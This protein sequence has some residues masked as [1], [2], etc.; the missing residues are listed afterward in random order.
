MQ[1]RR[2]VPEAIAVPL[3]DDQCLSAV[4]PDDDLYTTIL[5]V[6]EHLVGVRPLFEPDAMSI[7]NDG[8][9][10]PSSIKSISG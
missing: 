3:T 4:R 7:R 10:V 1:R 8:S 9:I 6:S 2:N 5:L